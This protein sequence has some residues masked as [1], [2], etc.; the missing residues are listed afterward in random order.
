MQQK[1]VRRATPDEARW[2]VDLSARVQAALSAAGSLQVIGPL[3]LDRVQSAIEAGYAYLLEVDGR[4]IGSVLV[5][6]VP[7]NSPFL[8]G[9]QLRALPAP[10]WFLSKLMLE[11]G[12]Q[13]KG[14]GLDFLAG[15]KELVTPATGTILLDCWA[16][17]DGLRDF[18]RRAGFMLHGVFPFKDFEVAIFLYT[19]LVDRSK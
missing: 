2:I 12:E 8:D 13:S 11:P 17:S 6:P 18:Y 19:P 7:D 14:F 16:G 10:L 15:V 3:P 1:N 4:P 9:W 5:E